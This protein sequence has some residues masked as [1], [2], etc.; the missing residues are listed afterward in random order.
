[1]KQDKIVLIEH[2]LIIREDITLYDLSKMFD[3]FIRVTEWSY[4]LKDKYILNGVSH[5]IPKTYIS[6]HGNM[7]GYWDAASLDG[8]FTFNFIPNLD[9]PRRNVFYRRFDP[10]IP[11]DHRGGFRKIENPDR[12]FY[13]DFNGMAI[14]VCQVKKGLTE[15]ITNFFTVIDPKNILL[16]PMV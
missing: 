11:Q 12:L 9:Y 4:V 7:D 6:A 14:E 1:M 3:V 16:I 10:N 5:I 15:E 8:Y 13:D 2:E